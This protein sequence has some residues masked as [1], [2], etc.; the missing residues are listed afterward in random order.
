MDLKSQDGL[1]FSGDIPSNVQV[2]LDIYHYRDGKLIAHVKPYANASLLEKLI[3]H[4]SC[5][6]LINLT[7]GV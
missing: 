1:G 3:F 4:I 5:G 6:K 7:R 2:T